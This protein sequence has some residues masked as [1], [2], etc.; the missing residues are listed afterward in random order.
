M[1][2]RGFAKIVFHPLPASLILTTL[3]T[4][5]LYLK[6]RVQG[7]LIKNLMPWSPPRFKNR[8]SMMLVTHSAVIQNFLPSFVIKLPRS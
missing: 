8:S 4:F 3:I 6:Q 5:L 7:V 1:V 2:K